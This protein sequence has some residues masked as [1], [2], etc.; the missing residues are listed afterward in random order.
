MLAIYKNKIGNN[1]DLYY[2]DSYG[3]KVTLNEI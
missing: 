2:N 3:L 1:V